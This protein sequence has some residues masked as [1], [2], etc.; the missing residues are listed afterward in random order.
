MTDTYLPPVEK[1]LVSSPISEG[2]GI[3]LEYLMVPNVL[4]H[5]DVIPVWL[6][7]LV[8]SVHNCYGSMCMVEPLT[9]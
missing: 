3:H 2:E 5:L 8:N 6:F 4:Y 9:N 7:A 1:A